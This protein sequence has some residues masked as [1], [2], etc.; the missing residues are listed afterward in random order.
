MNQQERFEAILDKMSPRMRDEFERIINRIRDRAKLAELQKLLANGDVDAAIEYLNM[1]PEQFTPLQ[2]AVEAAMKEGADFQASFSAIV[3]S[4]QSSP[5]NH[6]HVRAEQII[7]AQGGDL[8]QGVSSELKQTVREYVRAAT[9]AGHHPTKV[10]KQLLGPKNNQTKQRSGGVLGLTSQQT[11][12]TLNAREELQNLDPSYLNR[13]A[14]DTRYDS[15]LRKA[16]KEGK[17][18]AQEQIDKMIQGYSKKLLRVRAEIIS[19]TETH[20]ALNAGRY[21]SVAQNAEIAG[22]SLDNI[23]VTWQ[24]AKDGRTRDTHRA[25]NG[26][27]VSYGEYF[28]TFLF[29]FLKYPGDESGDA[30]G[31]DIIN[32]RCSATYKIEV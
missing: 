13:K 15:A 2:Q 23:K 26:K 12:F 8:I 14:R 24:S 6:R 18:L 7:M 29:N 3:S 28:Q 32:C 10:A 5:F 27:T 11:Q 1:G 30:G 19:R 16:I 21:E 20:K 17:P 31:E 22:V 4:A 9:E 25:L